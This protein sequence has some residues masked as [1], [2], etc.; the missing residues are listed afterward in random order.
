MVAGCHFDWLSRFRRAGLMCAACEQ[1][2]EEDEGRGRKEESG[3]LQTEQL[4][5]K[6]MLEN[7]GSLALIPEVFWF[8]FSH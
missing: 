1:T 5:V 7:N 8:S 2:A 3:V 4:L 6:T